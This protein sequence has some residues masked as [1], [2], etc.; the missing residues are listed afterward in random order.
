MIM[1][2]Q[3]KHALLLMH[4]AVHTLGDKVG[5]VS[6]IGSFLAAASIH[7]Y[8]LDK[9]GQLSCVDTVISSK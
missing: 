7:H 4:T 9:T 6:L 2:S 5:H 8:H 3:R 1:G